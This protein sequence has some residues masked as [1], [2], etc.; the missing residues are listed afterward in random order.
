MSNGHHEIVDLLLEHGADANAAAFGHS[1]LAHAALK[2]HLH[3]VRVLLEHGAAHSDTGDSSDS[4]TPT[5]LAAAGGHGE[6]INVL[7]EAGA[8]HTLRDADGKTAADYAAGNGHHEIAR[9][10]HTRPARNDGPADDD[11]ELI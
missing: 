5:M 6:I 1:A 7:L 4:W 9:K 2:N 10:L 3:C 8:D 11:V